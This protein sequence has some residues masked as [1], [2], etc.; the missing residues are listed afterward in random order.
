VKRVIPPSS[1]AVVA[2]ALGSAAAAVHAY[3]ERPIRFIIPFAPAGTSDIVGRLLAIK[4]GQDLGQSV[5]VDNRAGGGSTVGTAIAAKAPPDGYTMILSHVSLAINQSLYTSLPFDANRDFLPVTRV[6]DAPNAVVVAASLPVRTM[7]DLLALARRQPGKLDY[8]SGGFGSAGH[9]PVA[10]LED[11]SGTRFNHIPYK[12]GGPSVVAVIAGEVQFAMPSVPTAA[13]HAK[14]GRLRVIAVTGA[15]RSAAM[16]DAPTIAETVPGYEFAIWYGV[17]VPAGTPR[18][19]VVR[20][21]RAIIDALRDGEMQR[22]L[23]QQGLEV[24]TSSP[25][26]LGGK[27]R[28][29]IVKWQKI[30][31]A[32][33][34]KPE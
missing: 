15:E 24:R 16:P 2:I 34:I 17:F 11:M 26:E 29:D 33:G 28:A 6:G 25:E 9:L 31:K 20:L 1:I 32:A 18:T 22:Q 27:L 13:P 7:G 3:P 4:L 10:L 8:G 21:N 30:V 14:Q 19:I 23:A 5:V 12:G